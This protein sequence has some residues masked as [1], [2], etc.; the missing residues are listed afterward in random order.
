[1][2]LTSNSRE[3][4]RGMG[5]NQDRRSQPK[6]CISNVLRVMF[7]QQ[8]SYTNHTSFSHSVVSDSLRPHGQQHARP[9]CPS[10][11]PGVYLNSCPLSLWCHPTISSSH[12]QSF[13]TS[14][15][16]QMSQLFP[17]G[18]QSIRAPESVLPMN[19][20]GWFILGFILGSPCS[21]RGSQESSPA[22]QFES[23]NSLAFSLL[24][25]PALTSMHTNHC[26]QSDVFAF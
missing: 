8:T 21:P 12:L 5:K 20:Q 9:P 17:S 18:G 26:Q 16:F 23:I 10:P 13:P 14:G 19:I 25:G 15:S 4:E 6:S 11:A 1:M 3:R 24:Y 7:V 22:S 2:A